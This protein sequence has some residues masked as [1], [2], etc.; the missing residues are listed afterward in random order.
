LVGDP[1]RRGMRGD[2][3]PQD[4]SPAMADQQQSIEKSEGDGR[5]DKQVHRRNAIRMVAQKRL[6]ALGRWSSPAR[7]ILGDAGLPNVD[8]ELEQ[9]AV[10][11][12]RTPQWIGDTSPGSTAGSRHTGMTHT[13]PRLKAPITS[14]TYAMP[15][16]HGVGSNDGERTAGFRKQVT[17]PTQEH[18]VGGRK[19]QTAR[20]APS[21]HD[22][23]LSQHQDL[24][25][26]RR[27]CPE[28][29]N[30]SFKNYPAE[31]QHAPRIIR[32]CG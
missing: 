13:T 30:D 15:P 7:H 5:N 29:I 22:D 16:N 23:L 27:A 12:W 6:P 21:Q 26:Q 3:E 10:D 1:F 9:F 28:Q 32:F 14:Q 8:A 4:L 19:L 17:D 31:I 25:L 20:F 24:G 11:A 2:A 18:S